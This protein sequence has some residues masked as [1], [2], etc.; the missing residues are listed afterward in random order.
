MARLGVVLHRGV[1][2]ITLHSSVNKESLALR[3]TSRACTRLLGMGG[4][5][6]LV[7]L[8][9]PRYAQGEGSDLTADLEVESF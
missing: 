1:P 3:S 5:F 4:S 2:A 8:S 7:W 6:Q 9:T